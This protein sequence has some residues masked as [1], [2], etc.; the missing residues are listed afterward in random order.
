MQSPNYLLVAAVTLGISSVTEA[1]CA[2]HDLAIGTASALATGDTQWQIYDTTCNVQYTYA[3]SSAITICDSRVFYCN[4]G[5]TNIGQYDDPVTGW[6]YNAT[7][8][9]IS[10]ACGSD[11]IISCASAFWGQEPEANPQ[12]A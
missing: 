5:T 2:G 12:E 7:T 3:Q 4:V 8:D 1:V 11:A 10:E 9:P 6:A